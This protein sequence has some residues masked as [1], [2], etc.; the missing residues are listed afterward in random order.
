MRPAA[1]AG[2]PQDRGAA[3]QLHERPLGA[4]DAGGGRGRFFN[5][6]DSVNTFFQEQSWNQVSSVARSTA[7]TS[8]ASA[9]RLQ[10]DSY[11]AAAGATAA[12]CSTPTTRSPTSSRPAR[13]QLGGPGR[14]ARR[15]A[16]AERR[17]QRAGRFARARSQHGRPPRRLAA[18][19]EWRRQRRDQLE[20]HDERVRRPVLVDGHV[21]PADGR[22]H[23]Q[24]LG[25]TRRTSRPSPPAGPTR[26]ARRPPVERRADPEDPAH[27]GGLARAVLLP[28]PPRTGRRVRQLRGGD[29]QSRASRPDRL[30]PR[31]GCSR[32]CSTPIRRRR[33]TWTR[34]SASAGRSATAPCRSPPTPS[35]PAW[36][37]STSPGAAAPPD[38]EAPSAPA[39]TSA[40]HYG[41]Y[42]DLSWTAATD[43]VGVA[44]Y[45][46]KRNGVTVATVTGTSHRDWSVAPN[47][48]YLY[49][50]E[51]FDAAGNTRISPYCWSPAS[52][53]AG[54]P[55]ADRRRR[56]PR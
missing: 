17:H 29:P 49:C 46:V 54:R 21:E 22:W 19:H 24:Q 3:V 39:V 14:A 10:Q 9:A 48:D 8:S 23:L 15:P 53:A 20:L 37:R 11:A 42:V 31:R 34:R 43:N 33:P 41:S 50:V 28:R 45:R 47:G 16:L 36:P 52:T 32:S 2:R 13:L 38:T 6:G 40:V 30:Q 1:V 18:L 4:V 35:P 26:S 7:G 51:A 44:G 12:A 56:R 5:A 27:P 55:A 25:Y